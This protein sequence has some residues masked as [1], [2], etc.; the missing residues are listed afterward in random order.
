MCYCR[1]FLTF[2]WLVSLA[3]VVDVS[4]RCFYCGGLCLLFAVVWL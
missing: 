3:F 2:D 4:A 1:C